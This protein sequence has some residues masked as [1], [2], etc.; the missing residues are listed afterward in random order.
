MLA[1]SR[2][3]L[4]KAFGLRSVTLAGENL[5]VELEDLITFPKLAGDLIQET[6]QY[7]QLGEV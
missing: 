6:R 4:A 5:E 2:S 3:C 7:E 1:I